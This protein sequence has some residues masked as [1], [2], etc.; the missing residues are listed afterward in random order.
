[1]SEIILVSGPE[2]GNSAGKGLID[3]LKRTAARYGDQGCSL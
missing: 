2:A 3:F 1:M